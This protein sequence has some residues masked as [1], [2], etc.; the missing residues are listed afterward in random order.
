MQVHTVHNGDTAC[1]LGTAA[2]IYQSQYQRGGEPDIDK[3]LKGHYPGQ[4]IV[5]IC[6]NLLS[7]FLDILCLL[8]FTSNV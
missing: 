1:W 4:N 3:G 7:I 5:V 8:S 6:N 2:D